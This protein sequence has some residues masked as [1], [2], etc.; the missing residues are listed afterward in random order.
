MTVHKSPRQEIIE[1]IPEVVRGMIEKGIRPGHGNVSSSLIEM[2]FSP[3]VTGSNFEHEVAS[4][5]VSIYG[6]RL[7]G[8]FKNTNFGKSGYSHAKACYLGKI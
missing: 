1:A 3:P 7:F 5:L 4:A 6:I 2:G 8:D